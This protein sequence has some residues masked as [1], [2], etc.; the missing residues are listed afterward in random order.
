MADLFENPEPHPQYG[1]FCLTYSLLYPS[2]LLEYL[3]DTGDLETARDLWPV[4]RHQVAEAL[5]R[6]RADY[7]CD[8]SRAWLFFDHAVMDLEV[9]FQ[10]AMLFALNQCIELGERIGKGD[11]VAEWKALEKKIRNGIRSRYFDK[12]SGLVKGSNGEVSVHSQ[13]WFVIGGVLSAKEGRKA[14][15]AALASDDA[16]RPASP[17]A[18]HYLVDAMLRCGM[19]KEARAA[20]EEYWGGMVRKGAD[21]FWEV[22]DRDDDLRSPYSFYPLNS[23]CHAWGCTPTYFIYSYPEVFQSL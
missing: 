11:D 12:R 1:T 7:T 8:A 4:A 18:M 17:Y 10:G 19:N 23:Y 5:R 3:N 9:P 6:V 22:Y 2:V 21:T 13:M 16:I 15:E 20:V 14:L